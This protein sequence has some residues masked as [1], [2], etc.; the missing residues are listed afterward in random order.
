LEE[1]TRR[2]VAQREFDARQ[3]ATARNLAGQFATPPELARAIARAAGRMTGD[4]VARFGEPSVGTGAFFGALV[5]EV[6]LPDTAWGVELDPELASLCRSFWSEYGLEV[7]E[8][9]F[10]QADL[11]PV[12]LLLA[13]PPY[14][15]HHHLDRA[16]KVRLRERVERLAGFKMHGLAGLYA[17]FMVLGT[18]ALA[19]G[20]LAVWLVPSEWLYVGYG[21]ALRSWLARDLRVERVHI[22]DAAEKQFGDALVSSSVVFVRRAEPA[23]TVRFTWGSC[24]E[25]PD[26][27]EEVSCVELATAD[28][29]P[30]VPDL[31]GKVLGDYF[32]VTR[33]VAT[34]ANDF[35]LMSR[36][37]ASDLGLPETVLSPVLPSPRA[38]TELVIDQAG[39]LLLLDCVDAPDEAVLAYLETGVASALPDR[40]LLSRRRP[41]YRQERRD[42]APFV[43]AYMGRTQP[44]RIFWNRARLA[45]TNRWLLLYPREGLDEAACWES[46][47]GI[48]PA[49]A[50]SRGRLYGGGLYKIEPSELARLPIDPIGT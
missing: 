45:A 28:R 48:D 46:L 2:L 14:V 20:G 8:G 1:E 50:V 7:I 16:T 39:D 42:P 26:R 12:D 25:Q 37:Q 10:T 43:C 13:N 40:Y 30:P 15:R 38:L 11:P 32:K 41:W 31:G 34:G 19:P 24:L 9:D 6:G 21:A 23:Q 44:L 18:L 3:S 47:C 36:A 33:G 29:W 5:S 27:I 49:A 35:F 17:Y 4:T 22:F